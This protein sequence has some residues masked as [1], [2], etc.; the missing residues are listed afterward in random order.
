MRKG[1]RGKGLCQAI[2]YGYILTII[3]IYY[4]KNIVVLSPKWGILSPSTLA[5]LIPPYLVPQTILHTTYSIIPYTVYTALSPSTYSIITYSSTIYSII[6]ALIPYLAIIIK[7]SN[8]YLEL[9]IDRRYYIDRYI[10]T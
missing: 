7:K 6:T 8:K 2:V 1:L 4:L 5:P 3:Y 10:Y 9:F